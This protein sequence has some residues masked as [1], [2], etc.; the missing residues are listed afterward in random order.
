MRNLVVLVSGTGSLL[1]A[2]IDDVARGKVFQISCV[3]SDNA[4]CAALQRNVEE[5]QERSKNLTRSVQGTKQRVSEEARL[6]RPA[7]GRDAIAANH[8]R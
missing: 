3:I 2:L 4:N 1:Q 7:I 5:G 8:F 6:W